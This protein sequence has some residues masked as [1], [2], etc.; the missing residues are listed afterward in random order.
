MS[1]FIRDS[2][3]TRSI[4]SNAGSSTTVVQS[5]DVTDVVDASQP[6]SGVSCSGNSRIVSSGDIIVIKGEDGQDGDVPEHRWVG[7]AL[8]FRQQGETWGPLVD[9]KG[10]TSDS[11][12]IGA[13]GPKGDTGPVPDHRWIGSVLQ[14]RLPNGDWGPAIDLKGTPGEK[15]EPGVD[16]VDGQDGAVGPKGD[17]GPQGV[18]A[19]GAKGDSSYTW[20]KYSAVASPNASQMF[21]S[22]TDP[23]YVGISYN[24]SN[25][26]GDGDPKEALPSEYQW[27]RIKGEPGTGGAQGIPG[28]PGADGT[29]FTW[30]GSFADYPTT[31]Q[32]GTPLQDGDAFLHTGESKVY[33]YEAGSWFLMLESGSSGPIG[34]QG[35][36]GGSFQYQGEFA[37]AP[38]N[39]Q[40]NWLYK[41]TDSD[42]YYTFTG[43]SWEVATSDGKN[44][45]DGA[46]VGG[47]KRFFTT[48]SNQGPNPGRPLGDGNQGVWSTNPHDFTAGSITWVAQK[49]A[50]DPAL[51]IWELPINISSHGYVAPQGFRGSQT[52]LVPIV[53]WG[54]VWDD[55]VAS[56]ACSGGAPTEWDIV[57]IYDLNDPEE[58][59][60]KRWGY[61]SQTSQWEWLAYNHQ[62]LGDVIVDGTLDAV[63][64][65][66]A[67]TMRVGVGDN[68][69][70]VSGE[71]ITRFWAGN[72]NASVAPFQVR[73]DGSLIATQ[74]TITAA[75]TATSF[76]GNVIDSGNI[77]D[78]AI[79]SSKIAS[80]AVTADAILDGAVTND[81]ILNGALSGSK[82]VNETITA[83]QLGPNSITTPKIATNAVT[84]DKIVA[85]AITANE[86][87]SNAV[88]SAKITSN[89]ITSDKI[90]AN[91]I[92]AD[93]I[94]AGTISAAKI[95]SGSLAQVEA[96]SS[97]GDTATITFST[98][99]ADSSSGILVFGE[100]T[101]TSGAAST[102]NLKLRYRRYNGSWSGWSTFKETSV[103]INGGGAVQLSGVLNLASGYTQ[104]QI[105]TESNSTG[106]QGTAIS[107]IMAV[108]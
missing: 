85:N 29:S 41:D 3:S 55:A 35:A 37:T 4:V 64:I 73:Q 23:V 83:T 11:G 76:N 62:F 87:A 69:G 86:I 84:S 32:N 16:G 13:T 26:Q 52:I 68:V 6:I 10:A 47:G 21:D 20:I 2:R 45:S 58:Q 27:N 42:I 12:P 77:V 103:N 49:L 39:P 67:T 82:L 48:Y 30:I 108:R 40:I 60:T 72:E 25:A 74:A 19:T 14:F 94:D 101:A 56:S 78:D 91:A 99:S 5:D 54:G 57:T 51:G 80:N 63:A 53:N 1:V 90:A 104:Y 22:M 24:Q 105:R 102:K 17:Q 59:I 61:N 34:P 71:G 44:T 33:I 50:T 31:R 66:A 65:N 18:G 75:V 97:T 106:V 28:A 88:T 79:T 7:T 9:L 38:T 92:T 100:L 107:G 81:A 89:A 36:P 96:G 15:G 70:V 8:Q 95:V 43:Q 93:K 98:S 46:D